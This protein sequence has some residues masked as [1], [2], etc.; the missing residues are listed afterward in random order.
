M[1][2]APNR[3]NCTSNQNR[4]CFVRYLNIKKKKKK[5]NENK[6]KNKTKQNILK[7]IGENKKW[8]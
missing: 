1:R 6:N 8:H 3:R 5:K 7:Q 2:I 4:A